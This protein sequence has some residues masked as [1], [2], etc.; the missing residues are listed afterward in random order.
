[1]LSARIAKQL[2]P[3]DGLSHPE[4]K[5][6]Q[7]IRP[8]ASFGSSVTLVFALRQTTGQGKENMGPA[9]RWSLPCGRQ[10]NEE[11]PPD[12]EDFSMLSARIALWRLS[13]AARRSRSAGEHKRIQPGRV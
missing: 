9:S 4:Q 2:L 5:G 1:M 6:K 10:P 12:R 3:G 11:K 8:S 13:A 7:R